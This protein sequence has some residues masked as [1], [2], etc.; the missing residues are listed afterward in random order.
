[1]QGT[2]N[3]MFVYN[4]ISEYILMMKHNEMS[5][6]FEDSMPNSQRYHWN[7]K[8]SCTLF[9]R[10]RFNR[11]CCESDMPLSFWKQSMMF[12]RRGE[13]GGRI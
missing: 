3:A 5:T 8:I 11:Y 2:I 13:V 9:I 1:M 12:E 4:K 7:M 10:W 6:C